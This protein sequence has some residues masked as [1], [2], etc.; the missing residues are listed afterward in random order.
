[1]RLL[2]VTIAAG[3]RTQITTANIYAS[4]MVVQANTATAYLGDDT[5]TS[6][7]GIP[8]LTTAAPLVIPFDI[9]RGSLLSQYYVAGTTGDVVNILYETSE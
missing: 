5:V 8:L 2:S 7:T 6:T 1:M 3:T 9:R 4:V